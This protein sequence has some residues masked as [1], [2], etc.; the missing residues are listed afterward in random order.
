[1]NDIIDTSALKKKGTKQEVYDG[2]AMCT[3]GGL[4]KEDLICN[5]KNKIVSKKRSE[6]GKKQAV[7]L[8]GK[9][10]KLIEPI[11]EDIPKEKELPQE[12]Q[13]SESDD[14]VTII[15]APLPLQRQENIR[16][17]SNHLEEKLNLSRD[18]HKLEL[19]NESA[20]QDKG[21]NYPPNF[22]ERYKLPLTPVASGEQDTLSMEN[23]TSKSK[24]KS[25]SKEPKETKPRK[26]RKV[27]RKME[28]PVIDEILYTD[29]FD[30]RCDP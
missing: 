12:D 20:N 9:K 16:D 25:K 2:A 29:K 14:S 26:P 28:N 18:E 5:A 30:N 7:H 10:N 3:A 4:K 19:A 22:P 24:S 15:S 13:E 21:F 1:M 11:K 17:D 8:Q 23:N 27:S 6:Q